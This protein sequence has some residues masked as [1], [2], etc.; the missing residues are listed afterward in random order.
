MYKVIKLKEYNASYEGEREL[1]AIHKNHKGSLIKLSEDQNINLLSITDFKVGNTA[2]GNHYHK[3]KEEYFYLLEGRVNAY[4]K[5]INSTIIDHLVIEKGT[6]IRIM[7]GCIHVFT[8]VEDGYAIEYCSN[9]SEE[10]AHDSMF[11]K[12]V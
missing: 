1:V 12:I 5:D 7:P 9:S 10:I 3:Y 2:R 6:L 8:T 11:E 4:F